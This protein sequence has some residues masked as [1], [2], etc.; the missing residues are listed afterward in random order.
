MVGIGERLRWA[1]L[2]PRNPHAVDGLL[3]T[4][5]AGERP[6]HRQI[7]AYGRGRGGAAAAAAA[8]GEVPAVS[9]DHIGVEIADDRRA[10]EL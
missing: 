2:V 5:V 8:R 6:D 1:G 10:A 4:E 3:Q 7:H 9:G